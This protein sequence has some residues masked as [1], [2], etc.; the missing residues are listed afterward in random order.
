MR[1]RLTNTDW[2]EKLLRGTQGE[3]ALA[4]GETRD[5]AGDFDPARLL[6]AGILVSEIPPRRAVSMV[7]D[8]APPKP[9]KRK[10]RAG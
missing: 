8:P 9:A 2:R 1:W 5:V 4:P 3:F 6:A 7:L 10:R